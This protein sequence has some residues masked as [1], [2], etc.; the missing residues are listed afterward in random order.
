VKHRLT[1]AKERLGESQLQ[2]VLAE[3]QEMQNQMQTLVEAALNEGTPVAVPLVNTLNEVTSSHAA[4]LSAVRDRLPP[5]VV[6]LLCLAAI[7]SM[8]L[9]G[10]QQGTAGE[11]PLGATLGL[12]VLVSM[13]V[14]VTLDLNQPHRGLITVSQEPLERLLAGMGN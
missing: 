1:L 12:I 11:R 8:L 7:V 5:S 10:V 2:T 14:W 9:V 3:S 13:I 6:I 4:R